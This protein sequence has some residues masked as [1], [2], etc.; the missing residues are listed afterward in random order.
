MWEILNI[1]IWTPIYHWEWSKAIGDDILKN[2][3]AAPPCFQWMLLH[4]QE[5]N[6][7]ITYWH[8]SSRVW[9]FFSQEVVDVFKQIFGEQKVIKRGI[10]NNESHFN[11]FQEFV[12]ESEFEYPTSSLRYP[13]WNGMA[14]QCMLSANLPWRKQ[15]RAT[16]M[17]TWFCSS[18][19]L[20][21]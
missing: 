13:W 20:H 12:K 7:V 10:N 16:M 9:E 4:L 1:H 17:S 2:F 19:E 3:T 8:D 15:P 18:L 21:Q 5:Y 6:M 11:L 14:E